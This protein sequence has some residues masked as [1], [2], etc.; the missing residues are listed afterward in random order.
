M[1]SRHA[2]GVLDQ[3]LELVVLSEG[4]D[5]QHGTKL[6]E[7]L[8]IKTN[9]SVTRQMKEIHSVTLSKQ[10][11]GTDK[12]NILLTMQSI[13]G[14]QTQ[15]VTLMDAVQSPT[16]RPGRAGTWCRTSRVTG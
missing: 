2:V 16:R 4:D 5:L 10:T 6:G 15:S 14:K 3:S 9:H 12:L 13:V 1:L 11:T 8:E 7:D